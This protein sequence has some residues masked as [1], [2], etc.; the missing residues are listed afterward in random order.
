[1][2]KADAP[3]SSLPL[4]PEFYTPRAPL[5]AHSAGFG[6]PKAK[7][8]DVRLKFSRS[9]I[10]AL[11]DIYIYPCHR[12]FTIGSG[13]RRRGWPL[14][15]G[16]GVFFSFHGFQ[17]DLTQQV[18]YSCINIGVSCPTIVIIMRLS[19]RNFKKNPFSCSPCDSRL[20]FFPFFRSEPQKCI[21]VSYELDTVYNIRGPRF[22]LSERIRTRQ[23]FFLFFPFFFP[24]FFFFFSSWSQTF[25]QDSPRSS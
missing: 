1:V 22:F 2:L 19:C 13:S 5:F 25:Q 17:A 11:L 15:F 4:D 24:L 7:H 14:P 6:A 8:S 20:F 3:G 16:A 18:R 23:A 21:Q 9:S 10:S 12:W